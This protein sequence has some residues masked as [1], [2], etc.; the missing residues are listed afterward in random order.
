M[1]NATLLS[2]IFVLWSFFKRTHQFTREL[3]Y[4]TAKKNIYIRTDTP[5]PVQA[6]GELVGATPVDII[7]K[8]SALNVISG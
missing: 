6:D 4:F 1:K 5:L 3:N 8:K 2:L 7:V